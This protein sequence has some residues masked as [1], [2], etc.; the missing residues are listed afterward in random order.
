MNIVSLKGNWMETKFAL[1]ITLLISFVKDQTCQLLERNVDAILLFAE[2]S[3]R[4]FIKL[5]DK[6]Y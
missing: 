1:V 2:N 3:V 5:E 4:S 6:N